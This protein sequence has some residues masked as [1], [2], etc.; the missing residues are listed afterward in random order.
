MLETALSDVNHADQVINTR[1][2]GSLKAVINIVD[3][4]MYTH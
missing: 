4:L 2:A 3:I 1:I